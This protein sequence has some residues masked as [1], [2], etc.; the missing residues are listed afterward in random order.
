MARTVFQQDHG[1]SAY[2][3]VVAEAGKYR[4]AQPGESPEGF[5]VSVGGPSRFVVETAGEVKLP[6][7]I[8]TPGA[9]YTVGTDGALVVT[10]TAGYGEATRFNALKLTPTV[11]VAGI[12]GS[13]GDTIV[14]PDRFPNFYTDVSVGTLTLDNG[15][16]G[17][18]AYSIPVSGTATT[19][20]GSQTWTGQNTYATSVSVNNGAAITT[21]TATSGNTVYVGGGSVAASNTLQSS[22]VLVQA[23]TTINT[24]IAPA[25]ATTVTA[26]GGSVEAGTDVSTGG[27]L[28]VHGTTDVIS[29]GSGAYGAPIVIYYNPAVQTHGSALSWSYSGYQIGEI[30]Y[31]TTVVG[32][33]PVFRITTEANQPS[34]APSKDIEVCPGS[35]RQI[36]SRNTS[37]SML[38]PVYVGSASTTPARTLDI[39]GTFRASGNSTIGGTFGVTGATTLSS[40]LA[41]TDTATF[42]NS[43]NVTGAVTA[44]AQIVGGTSS[45]TGLGVW[46]MGIAR[47]SGTTTSSAPS[48]WANGPW[49]TGAMPLAVF[50]DFTTGTWSSNGTGV[51]INTPSTFTGNILDLQKDGASKLAVSTTMATVNVPLQMANATADP[52]TEG[53]VFWDPNDHTLAIRPDVLGSTLQVGQEM[54][55]RVVNKTGSL[56]QDGTAVY[57][58]GAQGN[59]PTITAAI[60]TSSTADKT[61]GVVTS[62]IADNAEGLVTIIGTVHGYN[63]SSFTTG[64]VLYLSGTTAGA[65]TNVRPTA[66]THAVRVGYALNSTNNGS[67]LVALHTGDA[68]AD[69][70]DTVLTSPASNDILRYDGTVWRNVPIGTVTS[71][72]TLSDV[73]ITSP[74]TGQIVQ[75]N[76]SQW[77]NA[78]PDS[79]TTLDA[80]TDTTITGPAAGQVLR[81]DGTVWRNYAAISPAMLPVTSATTL[82]AA[83]AALDPAHIDVRAYG[84]TGNGTTDDTSALQSALNAAAGAALYLPSG[85]YKVTSPL[86]YNV[87][88]QGT[89]SIFGEGFS[90]VLLISGAASALVISG[91][92]GVSTPMLSMH[93]FKIE[94]AG[95]ATTGLTLDGIAGYYIENV[96]VIGLSIGYGILLSRTQQGELSGGFIRTAIGVGLIGEPSGIASN[97]CDLHGV[98]F[99]CG[100]KSI[101]IKDVDDAFIHSNHMTSAPIGIDV[102]TSTVT[103]GYISIFSN[104][105]ESHSTGAIVLSAARSVAKIRDNSFYAAVGGVDVHIAGG[106]GDTIDS[107]LCDGTITID[108]GAA[109]TR[110]S[111]CLLYGTVTNN[112]SSTR[113][114]NNFGPAASALTNGVLGPMTVQSAGSA[115]DIMKLVPNGAVAG[116]WGMSLSGAGSGAGGEVYLK[117]QD[118][119]V[120]GSTGGGAL[121]VK[122]GVGGTTW[123][124]VNGTRSA[125][126]TITATAATVA[127]P[128]GLNIGTSTASFASAG[129]ASA[130]PSLPAGYLVMNLNGTN[131]K[132]PYYA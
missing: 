62:D 88:T 104:H 24:T 90:S 11:S 9:G 41:V 23:G 34:G 73:T 128:S 66:P 63:T 1:L 4:H 10:H 85:R 101:E 38:G 20:E 84:A 116:P 47:F 32:G 44:T 49:Y 81:Y 102:Q 83:R 114:W 18:I 100:S 113:F 79:L 106:T 51:G 109:E 61:I 53:S 112:S 15:F 5:V 58:N 46:S 110:I 48:V 87:D 19:L 39:G 17:D 91:T 92:A 6:P 118:V 107:C 95:S 132:L 76:G 131:I 22:K 3:W 108:S 55:V 78:A 103:N 30:G 129:S 97:G 59:R 37:I 60:A 33:T 105:F 12:T 68:L 93:D 122:S 42:S 35:I 64:D 99:N 21:T 28:R 119:V 72:D 74:T 67:I 7:G 52:G 14:V 82:A 27:V 70:H 111:N 120:A 121:L 40:T 115:G 57:V 75:Y 54:W 45:S 65:L 69:L 36:V 25:V 96:S 50:G 31:D 98:S 13:G 124:T 86:T 130:L 71:L 80:L 2:R 56:I 89:I 26:S 29:M 43:A 126:S 94:C 127:E 117:L 123:L 125:T 16:A 77:V 8:L